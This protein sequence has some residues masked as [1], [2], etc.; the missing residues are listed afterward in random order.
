MLD[1]QS[2]SGLEAGRADWAET[3]SGEAVCHDNESGDRE[4]K[5]RLTSSYRIV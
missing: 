5:S 2:V 3:P 4:R 1:A